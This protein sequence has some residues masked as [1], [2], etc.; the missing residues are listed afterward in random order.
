MSSELLPQS[1]SIDSQKEKILT[2]EDLIKQLNQMPKETLVFCELPG[3]GTTSISQK[4]IVYY[5]DGVCNGEAM[6]GLVGWVS[7][8]AIEKEYNDDFLKDA[9]YRGPVM[10]INPHY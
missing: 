5:K 4:E 7:S 2:V 8:E 3:R 1:M 9:K 6:N 10:V